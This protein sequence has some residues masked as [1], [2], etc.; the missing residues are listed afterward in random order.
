MIDTEADVKNGR[1][2]DRIKDR[3]EYK[4]LAYSIDLTKVAH[5]GLEPSHELE[6]EVNSN[7]LREQMALM[8]EGKPEYLFCASQ[9]GAAG[10]ASGFVLRVG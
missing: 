8:R 9:G 4:H 7:V 1:E 10:T 2:V 5:Q 6:L 3:I